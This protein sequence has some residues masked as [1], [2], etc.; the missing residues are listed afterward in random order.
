MEILL[1][2]YRNKTS[3]DWGDSIENVLF[4]Y[5]KG[6]EI[7]EKE[8]LK[9]LESLD[10]IVFDCED[11]MWIELDVWKGILESLLEKFD[12]DDVKKSISIK[13]SFQELA[14]IMNINNICDSYKKVSE[15]TEPEKE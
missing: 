8:N 1:K 15:E 4:S 9:Y 11:V 13:N 7:A 6:K 12:K 14:H 3:H 10:A 2:N 5:D